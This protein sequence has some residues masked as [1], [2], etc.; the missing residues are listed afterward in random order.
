MAQFPTFPRVERNSAFSAPEKLIN[1][2]GDV[3]RFQIS[4][5]FDRIVGFIILLNEASKGKSCLDENL[6]SKTTVKAVED[7][8]DVLNT[9]IDEIPPSTGPRRFGNI[10]FRQWIQRLEEVC[11]FL[12]R[13]ELTVASPGAVIAISSKGMSFCTC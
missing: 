3:A 5:A 4:L 13:V 1:T 9:Y 12:A 11:F 2:E 6:R 7:L 10:A 8:L